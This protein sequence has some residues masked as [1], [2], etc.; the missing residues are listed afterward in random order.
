[1]RNLTRH[2][3][4][5]I[6]LQILF[7]LDVKNKL[8][9][10]KVAEEIDKLQRAGEESLQYSADKYYKKLIFGVI[11]EIDKMDKIINECA[12]DWEISRMATVDRNILRIALFEMKNELPVGVAINEAVELAKEFGDNGSPA[13]IN[14]ILGKNA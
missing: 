5:I 12:I 10:A 6:A 9:Q 4:R 3:E 7:S 11:R 14:G 1:M 2:Q 13:F 8:Q